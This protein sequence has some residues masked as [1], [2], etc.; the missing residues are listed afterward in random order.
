MFVSDGPDVPPKRGRDA[1][2]R[3]DR[4]QRALLNE[5]LDGLGVAHIEAPGEAEAECCRLQTLGLV[6]A[7]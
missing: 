2:R 4:K 1:G 7:V 6:D 3:V 5:I